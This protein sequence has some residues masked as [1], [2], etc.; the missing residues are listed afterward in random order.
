[1]ETLTS[2]IRSLHGGIDYYSVNRIRAAAVS[3]SSRIEDKT[4]RETG[5]N[6]QVLNVNVLTE[7]E[8]DMGGGCETWT[9]TT[10]SRITSRAFPYRRAAAR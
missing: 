10:R 6:S 4:G 3:N 2:S 1:M 9:L 5:M 7:T 8:T